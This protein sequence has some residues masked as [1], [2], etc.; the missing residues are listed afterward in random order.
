MVYVM[1]SV[2]GN[3]KAY[4]SMKAK[5]NLQES[6]QLYVLGNIFDGNDEHPEQCLIILEDIMKNDNITLIVGNH[7]YWHL[8]YA[9]LPSYNKKEQNAIKSN[10]Q[11]ILPKT[12]PLNNF[13]DTLSLNRRK[14]YFDYMW[15]CQ[16]HK[17]IR[18]KDQYYFLSSAYPPVKTFYKDKTIEEREYLWK[19]FDNPIY[20]YNANDF[21]WFVSTLKKGLLSFEDKQ[22]KYYEGL[23]NAI[24]I[25]SSRPSDSLVKKINRDN[26]N[27]DSDSGYKK[28]NYSTLNTIPYGDYQR[29]I[30]DDKN[31]ISIDCECMGNQYNY[32]LNPTLACLRIDDD[33]NITAIYKH[34][35]Y[36]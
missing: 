36:E 16:P 19:M 15:S 17:I 26:E 2:F 8:L 14:H 5:I 4:F 3:A 23:E 33:N 25:T 7:E 22:I 34:N 32:R 20:Y 30:T 21:E 29:V 6:D 31:N 28:Y 9:Y 1:G 18:I 12:E 27:K 35:I 13:L 11:D 10:I 24:I